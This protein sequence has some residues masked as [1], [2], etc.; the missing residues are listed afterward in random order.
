MA[1]MNTRLNIEKLDGNIVQKHGGSKQVGFKQLGPG[2]KTG[3]HGVHYE[4]CVW[5]EVKLQGAQGD[6]E[7]EVFQVSNDDTALAQKWLED[8]QREEKTNTDC[9]SGLSKVLW[10]EDTTMS[11][12]LVTRSSAYSWD[13]RK[14]IMDNKLWRFD[15][16]TSKVVLYRN[17]G[18]NESG[19]YKKTFIGSGVGTGSMQMLH[20]FE[21]KGATLS[22]GTIQYREDS[23]EAAFVVAVV[24]KIYAHEALTF[25]DTVACEVI[26]KWKAG[27]KDDMDTRSD[28]YVL[29]N[30]Y[31]KCNDNNDGYYWEFTPD[32]GMLDKF[33]RGLQTDV[34]VFVDFDYAMATHMTLTEAWKKEIWLKGLLAEF[35]YELSL[36]AVIATGALV[37]GGSQ[38]EVPAQNEMSDNVED[39]TS[40]NDQENIQTLLEKSQKPLYAGCIKFSVLSGVLRLFG[41]KAK[42]RWTDTS[43]TDLLEAVHEMLPDGN[44]LPLSLYQA[45]KMMCPTELEV[46]RILAC[47]N[48]CILYRDTYANIHRCPICKESRLKQLFANEKDAKLLRWHSDERKKDGI[49]RHVADSP[50]W[51]KINNKHDEF[52]GE[53]RNIRF[54]LSSDG[55]NPFGNM[56]SKHSTWPVQ[57]NLVMT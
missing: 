28:V 38:F 4:K 12:Y 25:N 23:N 49:L 22:M 33:D 55:I 36:V 42:H 32:V 15:D 50:Q 5:F 40:D 27:L 21:F 37:K 20:G 31:K 48:D 51:R 47:P 14:G 9:L 24:E 17:M 41:V 45:K 52:G 44:E 11:T 10:A 53:I 18:F 56:S 39:T 29:S 30:G 3:V 43:F 1:S 46:E 57:N 34:H 6:R 54:G 26:S 8:K 13:Y 2:V 7:A 19:E 35:G 16:V